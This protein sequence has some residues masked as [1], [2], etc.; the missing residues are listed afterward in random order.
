MIN[1]NDLRL[2]SIALKPIIQIGKN[3]L[4]DAV[5]EEIRR[6]IKKKKIIK[7]K[8]TRG[9]LDG[10]DKKEIAKLI[11]EKTECVI[12][13]QIGFTVTIF[14]KKYLNPEQYK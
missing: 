14:P 4:S 8:L 12:I 13:S 11:S 2:K 9:C 3:G 6:I 10:M 1:L 5:I 7:I